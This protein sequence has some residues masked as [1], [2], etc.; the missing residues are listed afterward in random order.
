MITNLQ[1]LTGSAPLYRRYPSQSNPQDAF[2]EID[3]TG[4]VWYYSNPE[5]GNGVPSDVFH[6]T[7]R[8]WRIPHV[9]TAQGYESLHADIEDML[10][11]IADGIDTYWDGKN[12]VGRLTEDASDASDELEQFLANCWQND[13]LSDEEYLAELESA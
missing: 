7:S 4:A 10:Q 11:R 9:L 2:V 5:V 13:Y 1:K 6:G 8:R 12:T 3:S